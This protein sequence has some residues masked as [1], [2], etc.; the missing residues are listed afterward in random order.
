MPTYNYKEGLKKNISTISACNL[1]NYINI[2]VSDNSKIPLLNKKEISSF[3]KS[4]KDSFIYEHKYPIESAIHNWNYLIEKSES[5]YFLLMHQDEHFFSSEDIDILIEELI[6]NKNIF[7]KVLI[8]KHHSYKRIFKKL[9]NTIMPQ[10]ISCLTINIFRK[11][12]LKIN[13]IGPPSCL[14]IPK[15]RLR[16]DPNLKMLVDVDYYYKLLNIFK[17]NLSNARIYTSESGISITKSLGSNRRITVKNELKYLK[18]NEVFNNFDE[19]ILYPY[20]FILK[21]IKYF[22]IIFKIFLKR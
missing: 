21:T 1:K 19:I 4:M 10:K 20:A 3:E 8:L 13:L 6:Y 9:I 16:Y 15:N 5:Q 11:I 12:I 14:V 22:F 7:K 2:V 18:Q 17:F